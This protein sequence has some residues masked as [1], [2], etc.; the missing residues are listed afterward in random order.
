[1]STLAPNIESMNGLQFYL[2]RDLSIAH[3]HVIHID[4]E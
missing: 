4:S 2:R 3:G 1:L